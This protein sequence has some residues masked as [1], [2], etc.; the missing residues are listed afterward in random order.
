MTDKICCC[1]RQCTKPCECWKEIKRLS[2]FVNNQAEIRFRHGVEAAARILAANSIDVRGLL[3]IRDPD[4]LCEI[5]ETL[6]KTLHC[7]KCRHFAGCSV[8]DRDPTFAKQCSS[9]SLKR[10]Q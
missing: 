6:T 10:A 9:F 3:D 2:E 7:S 8:A 1:E 5:E 4:T